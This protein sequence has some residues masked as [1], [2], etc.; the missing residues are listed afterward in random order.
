MKIPSAKRRLVLALKIKPF[1]RAPRDRPPR[2][3]CAGAFV[4]GALVDG[5]SGA[6]V[7]SAGFW[8]PASNPMERRPKATTR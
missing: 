6:V 8:Q 2:N 1:C 3:Y 4:E 7:V 5:I